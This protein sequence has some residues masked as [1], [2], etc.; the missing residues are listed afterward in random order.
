LWDKII[1]YLNNN[2]KYFNDIVSS[3]KKIIFDFKE[4][5]ENIL[6]N[7]AFVNDDENF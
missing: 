6:T 3:K 4:L 7:F 1:Y 2:N 5:N